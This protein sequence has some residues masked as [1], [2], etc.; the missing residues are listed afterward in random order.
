M[1]GGVEH[2]E[3]NVAHRHV[4]VTTDPICQK[5]EMVLPVNDTVIIIANHSL[6]HYDRVQSRRR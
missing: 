4:T 3:S 1:R 2:L 6:H 5:L